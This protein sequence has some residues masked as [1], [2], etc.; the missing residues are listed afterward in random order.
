MDTIVW[1]KNVIKKYPSGDKEITALN[2]TSLEV[3]G[4]EL[5]LI[6]GP[7]GSGKTTLLL[8]LGG[9]EAPT[10]GEVT[11]KDRKLNEL[12]EDERTDLRLHNIGFVFQNINL[13]KPL[14][15]VEN[16]SFPARMVH[17]DTKKARQIAEEVVKKIG[18]GEKLNNYPEELSGGEQQRIAVARALVTNPSLLL[19]D[20]PTASLDKDSLDTVMKELKKS[21]ED[22]KAVVVV[23]HDKRLEDYADR[24]IEVVDG[25]IKNES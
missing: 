1:L 3:N 16:V 7:S 17:D 12:S 2:E 6:I 4:K 5:M 14:K 18:L 20:E 25:K 23:S 22:G 24:I 11:F 19:C 9:I 21:A 10:S 8:I 13:I 15:I